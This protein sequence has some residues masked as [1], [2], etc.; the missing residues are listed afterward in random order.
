MKEKHILKCNEEWSEKEETE[1]KDITRQNG[2]SNN[3]KLK[4]DKIKD[5]I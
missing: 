5:G 2:I 3:V 4:R 1:K